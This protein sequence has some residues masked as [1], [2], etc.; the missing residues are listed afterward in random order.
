MWF[1]ESRNC[2]ALRR[3]RVMA[4]GECVPNKLK[5]P[6]ILRKKYDDAQKVQQKDGDDYK[7]EKQNTCERI[8]HDSTMQISYR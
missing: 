4:R 6:F 8:S 5:R 7:N 2:G 1:V 3:A